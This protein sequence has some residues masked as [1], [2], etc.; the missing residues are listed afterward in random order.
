MEVIMKI[1]EEFCGQGNGYSRSI[2]LR[3]RL[4]PIGK[5][6]ENLKKANMLES[7][8]ERAKAYVEVKN[9]I[10]DFHRS[11]I[12]DVLSK[13]TLGLD[14]GALYDQ[15]DLFQSA[16]DKSKNAKHKKQLGVL[17]GVMRKD[18][19]KKFK[20]DGRYPKLFKK[21]ILTDLLPSIIKDDDTGTIT[22]KKAAL[23]T[24][25]G[26]ATYFTG[27]HQNRENLYSEEAKSTAI[28]NR[29]VNENFPK[30]YAN[31]KVFEDLQKNFPNIISETEDSL[32]DF[33]NGKKLSE[34]FNKENF[35][36]VL[37][38][39]GIDF[40]NT[41]IGGISGE[42]GKEKIQGLNEKINLASQKLLPED[43]SKLRKKMTLLYKQ[44]LSDKKTASFIPAGFEKSE[45]VYETVR[46]FKEQ[47]LDSAKFKIEKTFNSADYDLNQI[48]VPSKE[49]T[50]FSLAIFGN[51]SIL[52]EG[53]FLLEKD[54]AK[55][56]LIIQKLEY[57]KN[58]KE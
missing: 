57:Q 14:W 41:V 13:E 45:E 21:E 33:L 32:K 52:N 37:S 16:K 34:I 1:S 19:V 42:S 3:N 20:N 18:I 43:K 7:D 27:F 39:S 30:F 36:A 49:L 28:S 17:E 25:T 44:I 2:T 6:E 29:I 40:Y 35:N 11:F 51:W 23:D 47:N 10:D 56:D 24:F 38:Q 54:K 55:K 12:E 15:F 26:F 58:L 46:Q 50:A 48:F 22:D 5:T 31:V 53:F 9:I 4:I 8:F